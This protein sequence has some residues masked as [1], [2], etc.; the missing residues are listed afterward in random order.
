MDILPSSA[1]LHTLISEVGNSS[2]V[3]AS[4][5]LLESCGNGSEVT[6]LTLQAPSLDTHTFLFDILNIGRPN[7]VLSFLLR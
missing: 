7:L 5:D 2:N 6:Y 4:D 3:S 1:V